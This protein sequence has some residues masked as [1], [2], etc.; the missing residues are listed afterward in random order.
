MLLPDEDRSFRFSSSLLAAAS[1]P[2]EYNVGCSFSVLTGSLY[3]IAAIF[4]PGDMQKMREMTHQPKRTKSKH[5]QQ[6]KDNPS[7]AFARQTD[8]NGQYRRSSSGGGVVELPP[9]AASRNKNKAE[10]LFV[11]LDESDSDQHHGY[12]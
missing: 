2:C 3:L 6:P 9:A 5:T 11:P 8:Q 1:I 4:M 12:N 10:D 7:V